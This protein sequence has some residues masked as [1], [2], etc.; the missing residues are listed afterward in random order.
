[1]TRAA[2]SSPEPTNGPSGC[3][4]SGKRHVATA[5]GEARRPGPIENPR[6]PGR[7]FRPAI[8]T[9]SYPSGDTSSATRSRRRPL[10]SSARAHVIADRE[11][12][13]QDQKAGEGCLEDAGENYAQGDRFTEQACSE[14]VQTLHLGETAHDERL[15]E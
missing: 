10:S 13:Q 9:V 8:R 11:N 3:R 4:D 2:R 14:A 12:E 5:L 7:R 15:L 6:D 1:M